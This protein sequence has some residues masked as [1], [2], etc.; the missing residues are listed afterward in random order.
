ML[1]KSRMGDLMASH[2]E[3]CL[4]I[5]KYVHLASPLN[6]RLTFVMYT[7]GL[8]GARGRYSPFDS[9]FLRRRPRSIDGG[10]PLMVPRSTVLRA[11]TTDGPTSSTAC[12]QARRYRPA[13]SCRPARRCQPTV[14]LM[15]AAVT[16]ICR[17]DRPSLRWCPWPRPRL[18]PLVPGQRALHWPRGRRWLARRPS[19]PRLAAERCGRRE[20]FPV[21][22]QALFRYQTAMSDVVG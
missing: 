21:T 17:R 4:N 14:L 16:T 20:M 22:R 12:R 19:Q 9:R 10:R 11:H 15:S 6:A 2:Y 1:S 7:L 3:L 5:L 18:R 8:T 13:W